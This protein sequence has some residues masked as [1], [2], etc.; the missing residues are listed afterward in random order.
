MVIGE[1]E[2]ENM[3]LFL[4]KTGNFYGGYDDCIIKWGTDFKVIIYNLV[5]GIK[6]DM[7]II[8]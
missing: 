3:N 6:G 2:R 4:S 8:D 5:N 7:V 1:M